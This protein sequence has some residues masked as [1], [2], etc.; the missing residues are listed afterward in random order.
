MKTFHKPSVTLCKKLFK[1]ERMGRY[2][3]AF[4]ELEG[5][6]LDRTKL[7]E[8]DGLDPHIAAEIILRCGSLISCLGQLKQLPNAQ[9]KSKNLLTE[10]RNRFL[11]IYDVEK[12]AECENYMALAYWRSGELPEAEDWIAEAFSHD[13]PLSHPIMLY[14][15][16]NQSTILVSAKKYRKVLEKLG[17]LELV[18]L[19]YADDFLKGSFYNNVGIALECLDRIPEA[20]TKLEKGKN[21]YFKS[22]NKFQYAVAENNLSMLYKAQSNFLKAHESSDN[23][24]RIFKKIKDRTREGFSLDT[25][26]QIYLTEKKYDKALEIVEKAIKIIKLSENASFITETYLTKTKTLIHLDD[27]S[28]ATLCLF[29]AVELAKIQT[30]E[31][32]A[33]SL[34][35][36][37]ETALRERFE[38]NAAPTIKAEIAEISS[39]TNEANGERNEN[40]NLE[41]VLP[42]SIAHYQ[43]IQA[44]QIRNRH[45][46]S[47]GLEKG[48]L[49]IVAEIEVKKGELAAI[50]DLETD[51]VNCGFYDEDF[52][53]ICLE[54]ESSDPMLFDERKI[55]VLGK[56]VGVGKPENSSSNKIIVKPLI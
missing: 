29:G 32:A 49:A 37:Y 51:A 6:W 3:E 11:D 4:S 44:V 24:A 21:H 25:K 53:I 47:A 20:L 39:V 55:K 2:D 1:L 30:G 42:T 36:E 34:I 10:A 35:K 23:A 26:A 38:R 8:V 15:L 27:I 40:E 48:S 46:E 19:K 28:G 50:I 14:T 16:I 22:G 31:K 9:E 33:E 13:I 41:L 56:I 18:F 5:I 45:L 17:N 52:G 54:N 12:I 43:E 7:P